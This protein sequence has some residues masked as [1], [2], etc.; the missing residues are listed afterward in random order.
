MEK[1]VKEFTPNPAFQAT[2]AL[3]P[4]SYK[5]IMELS[6]ILAK[7]GMV[8]KDMIGR[9]E[10]CAA[11]IMYGMELGISPMNAV[12]NIM[13]VNGRPSAWGDLVK[14][15][16]MGSGRC[17]VFD[18]DPAH[19]ALKQGRGRCRLVRKKEFGGGEVE[20]EFSLEDAKRAKLHSK[21]G[22]WQDYPGRMLQ[23][24]ARSWAIRDLFPDVLK[25]FGIREELGD[26]EI[27][28]PP[29]SMPQRAKTPQNAVDAQI[30]GG[31]QS[32]IETAPIARET[33]TQTSRNE[34][35]GDVANDAIAPSDDIGGFKIDE[36]RRKELFK[37]WTELKIPL[38]DVKAFVKKTFGIDNTADLTNSQ[39]NELETWLESQRK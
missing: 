36:A 13:V 20:V 22:P 26:V 30:G 8:P 15:L 37:K 19:V 12:Q 39:S 2:G 6:G 7:S 11:A 31:G 23:M 14:A 25:G 5:Q 1:A 9:P 17:E 29:V 38:P 34:S 3:M 21:P 33:M 10:A 18:E 16:V 28:S 32:D 4:R 27:I 24:R 35:D